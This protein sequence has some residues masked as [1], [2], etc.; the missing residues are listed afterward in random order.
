MIP[1]DGSLSHGWLGA[2]PAGSQVA[3]FSRRIRQGQLRPS[4]GTPQFTPLQ[5]HKT[6]ASRPL[7]ALPQEGQTASLPPRS[8]GQSKSQGGPDSRGE[9][10]DPPC[11]REGRKRAGWDTRRG[12]LWKQPTISACNP[13]R[14]LREPGPPNR[15][16]ENISAD[17]P[18]SRAYQMRGEAIPLPVSS[19]PGPPDGECTSASSG[20]SERPR[21]RVA[22]FPRELLAAS[23]VWRFPSLTTCV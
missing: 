8:T 6:E 14:A 17:V 20:N 13:K 7:R 22:F 19:S 1:H 16:R 4:A 12:H 10:R 21:E 23:A 5:G 2:S 15:G 9:K 11:R 18:A 3:A